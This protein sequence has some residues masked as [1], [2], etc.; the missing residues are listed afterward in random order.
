MGLHLKLAVVVT[1]VGVIA[2]VAACSKDNPAAPPA[3]RPP[4][5]N[6]GQNQVVE[7]GVQAFLNGS[8]SSDP[9]GDK[10]SYA[11]TQ[12]FGTAVTLSDTSAVLPSFISPATE[13]TLAF[14]L[15][16]S[17]GRGGESTA[18]TIVIVLSQS[19]G[20]Q[21]PAANAGADQAVGVGTGA[22][23]HGSGSDPFGSPVTFSWVQFGGATVSLSDNALPMPTFT[24]PVT[25]DTLLFELTVTDQSSRFTRDS[26]RVVVLGAPPTPSPILYVVNSDETV[27]GFQNPQSKDGNVAPEHHL[28]GAMTGL[29]RAWDVAVDANRALIV[30]TR[31]STVASWRAGN[32]SGNVPP[33][34]R[35]SGSTTLLAIPTAVAIG[36]AIDVLF[37]TDSGVDGII[38][39]D[40]VS[41]TSFDGDVPSSRFFWTDDIPMTVSGA[42]YDPTRD[43]LYVYE[44][45]LRQ[46]LVYHDASSAN[47]SVAFSRNI[48]HT[49]STEEITDV[50]IDG[51]S[52]RL[53]AT[54]ATRRAIYVWDN[55]STIAVSAGNTAP[56]RT[57]EIGASPTA[58]VV[59]SANRGY[60]ADAD[61]AIRAFDNIH[62][63]NGFVSPTRIINGAATQLSSPRELYLVE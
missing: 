41:R 8:A 36:R 54:N 7:L 19:P 28:A 39:F 12:T 53:Y 15:A 13:G 9:D 33:D 62:T 56:T 1:L 10:L 4:T 42:T 25:P 14:E 23:L 52:D 24:A 44:T 32:Q 46:I 55:A 40:G 31:T 59:D 47:R 6:A 63:L 43:Q 11:W 35:V 48:Q 34:R 37:V 2:G 30:A 5:A 16:V 26:T 61:N 38:V 50:F 3:N 60:I 27:S 29:S 21:P 58:I 22:M 49:P 51:A 17:D 57:I 45:S 20:T 18:G